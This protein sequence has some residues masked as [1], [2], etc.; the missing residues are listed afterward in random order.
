MPYITE[1]FAKKTEQLSYELLVAEFRVITGPLLDEKWAVF[2]ERTI[3]L[4][5]KK[6]D[7]ILDFSQQQTANT[8]SQE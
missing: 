5:Y 7:Y 2:Y 6:Q 1:L 3:G 4:S 8:N